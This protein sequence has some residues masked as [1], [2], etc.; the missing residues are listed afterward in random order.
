VHL[1]SLVGHGSGRI[2]KQVRVRDKSNE[3][4]AVP[5]LLAGIDLKGMVITMDALLCQQEIARQILHQH[6]HY[7]MVVK[8]NQ[9]GLYTAIDLLFHQPPPVE[10]TDHCQCFTTCEKGHGR[11][12]TRTLERTAALNRYVEWPDVGQVLRRTCERII[13]KTGQVSR[14]VTYAVTSLGPREA[15]AEQVARLWREHW[16]IENKVHYVR[17]VTMGEDAGQVHRGHAPQA[18]AALRNG[19]LNL[20]RSTGATQ[21]ADAFRHHGASVQ[22]ALALLGISF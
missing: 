7:L 6:G 14:E 16:G 15:S 13:I 10:P 5:P 12:E 22:T 19:L 2:R 4:T 18:L 9:P 1:V 17:D 8:S 3:I 21:M 11:L 20:L